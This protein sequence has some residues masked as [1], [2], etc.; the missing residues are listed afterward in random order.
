MRGD[1]PGD[2]AADLG[3]FLPDDRDLVCLDLGR[4][5]AERV[6]V[7][8]GPGQGRLAAFGNDVPQAGQ[9]HASLAGRQFTVP[10]Q[11]AVAQS[12][13]ATRPPRQERNTW[14]SAKRVAV[15][16]GPA[17]CVLKPSAALEE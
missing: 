6:A 10:D 14:M 3:E 1:A 7:R 9:A 13:A 2:E 8:P 15:F 16:G 12:T 17:E 11:L 4:I 5:G